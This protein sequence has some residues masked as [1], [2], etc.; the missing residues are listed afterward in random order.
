MAAPPRRP[1]PEPLQPETTEPSLPAHQ[2]DATDAS[3]A[4]EPG[5]PSSTDELPPL[6]PQR[7]GKVPMRRT[8]RPPVRDPNL[9]VPTGRDAPKKRSPLVPVLLLVVLGLGGAVAWK[10]LVPAPAPTVDPRAK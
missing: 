9:R 1:R 10:K 5:G 4:H 3:P 7:K 8:G 6:V 2:P